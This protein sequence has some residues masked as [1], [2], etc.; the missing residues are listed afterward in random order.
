[1]VRI[2]SPHE[3]LCSRLRRARRSHD[4]VARDGLGDLAEGQS[5]EIDEPGF[6]FGDIL[7]FNTADSALDNGNSL[8]GDED[9]VSMALGWDFTLLEGQTAVID[10]VLS[11]VAPTQGFYLEHF[12]ENAIEAPDRIFFS[13]VLTILDP[14]PVPAP[15]TWSLALVGIAGLFAGQRRRRLQTR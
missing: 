14:A 7:F 10:M 1:M 11:L 8:D 15:P 6:V 12:D 13:S 5:W 4:G 2:F 9:D 3:V